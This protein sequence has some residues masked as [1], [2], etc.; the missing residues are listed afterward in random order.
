MP[1]ATPFTGKY[2]LSRRDTE[3]T[4][5]ARARATGKRSFVELRTSSARPPTR[6]R[7][8]ALAVTVYTTSPSLNR[9]GCMH[10][11]KGSPE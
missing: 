4:P 2:T 1:N 7:E 3:H 11:Y 5:V 9:Y 6:D 8:T 10:Y